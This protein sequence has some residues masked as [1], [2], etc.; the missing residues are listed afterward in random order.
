MPFEMAETTTNND[1]YNT[2]DFLFKQLRPLCWWVV[3]P[4]VCVPLRTTTTYFRL[5]CADSTCTGVRVHT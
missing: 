4:G 2:G 5:P 1:I 3:V